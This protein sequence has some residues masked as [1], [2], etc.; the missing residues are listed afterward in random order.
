MIETKYSHVKVSVLCV[1]K[2]MLNVAQFPLSREMIHSQ[3]VE[4]LVY[5]S[6]FHLQ[7]KWNQ[8]LKIKRIIIKKS[9][10]YS[11][12]K[13]CNH[14][15]YITQIVMPAKCVHASQLS[16]GTGFKFLFGLILAC[17]HVPLQFIP[18]LATRHFNLSESFGSADDYVFICNNLRH[19]FMTFVKGLDFFL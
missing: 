18:Q 17:T 8:W 13:F 15:A 6:M 12:S 4:I 11:I 1:W 14:S 5:C 9:T 2:F 7:L 10:K 19:W 3:K 16:D